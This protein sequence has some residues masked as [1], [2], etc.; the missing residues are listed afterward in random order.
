MVHRIAT[1]LLALQ[2][3]PAFAV[4][5]PFGSNEKLIIQKKTNDLSPPIKGKTEAPEGASLLARALGRC[6]LRGTHFQKP[7]QQ[8]YQQL[9]KTAK[10]LDARIKNFLSERWSNQVIQNLSIQFTQKNV[11]AAAQTGQYVGPLAEKAKKILESTTSTAPDHEALRQQLACFNDLSLKDFVETLFKNMFNAPDRFGWANAKI[12]GWATKE[13]VMGQLALKPTKGGAFL[14]NAPYATEYT[15]VPGNTRTQYLPDDVLSPAIRL[16]L[17]E[18]LSNRPNENAVWNVLQKAMLA[19]T[20]AQDNDFGA[21]CFQHIMYA[22]HQWDL[23]KKEKSLDDSYDAI[24]WQNR[25]NCPLDLSDTRWTLMQ[26]LGWWTYFLVRCAGDF[27]NRSQYKLP[28]WQNPNFET[29]AF[30]HFKSAWTEATP[31]ALDLSFMEK[32]TVEPGLKAHWDQVIEERK[33]QDSTPQVWIK[34]ET[35]QEFKP[36]I[37]AEAMA[38]AGLMDNSLQNSDAPQARGEPSKLAHQGKAQDRMPDL[39]PAPQPGQQAQQKTE[40][41]EEG[42]L[43]LSHKR[44]AVLQEEELPTVIL[45]R[46]THAEEPSQ[47]QERRQNDQ[48]PLPP[49]K[50]FRPWED[51]DR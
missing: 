47:I 5:N 25:D 33:P 6:H 36:D 21:H 4:F 34:E 41:P 31:Y 50:R 22:A 19:V 11:C 49:K 18:R 27:I 40:T 48:A 35:F 13:K 37:L 46:V 43:D 7:Q 20:V 39:I 24:V 32:T 29:D 12:E 8:Q 14:E 17:H 26:D 23:Y 44:A 16:D 15:L 45:E 9:L 2:I 10:K 28:I 51:T 1:F 42:P 3:T 38:G 30:K